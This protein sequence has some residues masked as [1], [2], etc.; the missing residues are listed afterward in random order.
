MKELTLNGFEVSSK[1]IEEGDTALVIR[2]DGRVQAY[3]KEA[4]QDGREHSG[5]MLN[6]YTIF[7]L[8]IVLG[9][10][11]LVELMETEVETKVRDVMRLRS[12]N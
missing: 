9:Q 8:M 6:L 5:D 4:A 1:P 3:V 7:A 2:S 10:R 11:D 12:V